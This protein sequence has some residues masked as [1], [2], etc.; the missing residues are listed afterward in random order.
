MKPD[1]YI[2]NNDLKPTFETHIKWGESTDKAHVRCEAGALYMRW[3]L[4]HALLHAAG[5]FELAK[6]AAAE[7]ASD[8]QPRPRACSVRTW[9]DLYLHP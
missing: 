5:V 2:L 8:M 6:K 9:P 7:T 3:Q 1:S 4:G